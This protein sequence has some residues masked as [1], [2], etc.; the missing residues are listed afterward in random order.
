MF[1]GTRPYAMMSLGWGLG[2]RIATP[3]SHTSR[4][5]LPL[6]RAQ[7]S[8]VFPEVWKC[9][10][11]CLA[12]EHVPLSTSTARLAPGMPRARRRMR[13]L[14]GAD[15]DANADAAPHP[16]CRRCHH[17][18]PPQA[19]QTS[20]R[21]RLVRQLASMSTPEQ[22]VAAIRGAHSKRRLEELATDRDCTPALLVQLQV[23]SKN[24][25]AQ[26]MMQ[27]QGGGRCALSSPWGLGW[28][29]C[30]LRNGGCLGKWRVGGAHRP[31]K[32]L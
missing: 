19:P 13:P 22:L 28:P 25:Q 24:A 4:G 26:H 9:Y 29:R 3:V 14:A 10:V 30:M 11:M 2:R 5:H 7:S 16:C 31:P 27:L 8:A 15:A 17:A 32:C 6:P 20:V 12:S 21:L 23:C 1:T 18:L